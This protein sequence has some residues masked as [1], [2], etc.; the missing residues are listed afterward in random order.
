MRTLIRYNAVGLAGVFVQLAVLNL[1]ERHAGLHYLPATALAVEAAVLHNF[2]WHWK[3]TWAARQ[4]PATS[5]WR[6]QCTT[7]LLS[8]AGNLFGMK[9]LA[10]LLGWPALPANLSTIAGLYLFNFVVADRFVFRVR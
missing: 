10:G 5:L 2:W 8:I 9:L 4:A 1:L 3:W 6:F 7:G